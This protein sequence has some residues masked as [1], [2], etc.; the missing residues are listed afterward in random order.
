MEIND[1]LSPIELSMA[2]K[3]C[4]IF[5]LVFTCLKLSGLCKGKEKSIS[6]PITA[7]YAISC[8]VSVALDAVFDGSLQELGLGGTA[9]R[10]YSSHTGFSTLAQITLGYEIYNT[11]V[12]LIYTRTRGRQ[13]CFFNCVWVKKYE[14][15][16]F[17]K[18]VSVFISEY[19]T[20]EFLGSCVAFEVPARHSQMHCQ[21]QRR[22]LNASLRHLPFV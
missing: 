22:H 10:L 4:G 7:A 17:L 2:L 3:L 16:F 12:S 21:L 18:Q 15:L 1:Y 6:H 19:R 20:A 5:S 13:L 14:W 9:S 11:L 8:T